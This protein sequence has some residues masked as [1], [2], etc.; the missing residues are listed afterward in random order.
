MDKK[1]G[2]SL[3]LKFIIGLVIAV[4]FISVLLT[5]T[6]KYILFGKD[7]KD[8]QKIY[9]EKLNAEIKNLDVNGEI[10]Q[11]LN[12]ESNYLIIS[13]NS[14]DTEVNMKDME[15]YSGYRKDVKATVKKPLECRE[16]C[17]CLCRTKN[18]KVLFG[19]DCFQNIC[20]D[21]REKIYNNGNPFFIFGKGITSLE[22]RKFV[23][24]IDISIMQNEQER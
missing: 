18:S 12:L 10:T 3:L 17:L 20:Q 19:D 9:F 11:I 14:Q 16:N 6:D 7:S 21:Y 24:K 1:A 2:V 13:F 15:I 4:M 5:L 22:I 23:D 8:Q